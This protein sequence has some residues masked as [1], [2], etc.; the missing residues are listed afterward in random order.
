MANDKNNINEL[1][2]D[3][4]DSTAE[5]EVLDLPVLHAEVCLEAS[6]GTAGFVHNS[7]TAEQTELAISELTSELSSRSEMIDRL[8]FDMEILKTKSQGLATEVQA[9]EEQSRKLNSQLKR[10]KQIARERKKLVAERDDEVRLLRSEIE[11]REKANR[12]LP[13]ELAVLNKPLVD[14]DDENLENRDNILAVQAGQ[15]ASDG[16][17]I[18]EL[19]GRIAKIEE[20]ADHLRELLRD[21]DDKAKQ[22]D[23]S[24][25]SL[26]HHLQTSTKQLQGL[27]FELAE[28][29]EENTNLNSSISTLQETHAEEIRVIRFELGDAQET[30]SQQ[31]ST[32]Q[33]LTSDLAQTRGY[34][35]KLESLLVASEANSNSEIEKLERENQ[36]LLQDSERLREKLHSKSKAI[37]SLL[38]ELARESQQTEIDDD[39]GETVPEL[40]RRASG[41]VDDGNPENRDRVTRVLTGTI[42]GQE[43]RFPLF[44]DR[45]TIGRTRKND[46]Q[47]KS[48]HISR[49]HAVVVI[50]GDVTRVIDWGSKNG[51]FVNANRVKEHFLKNND[52]VG[53]GT[54]E[55]R[56]EERPKRDN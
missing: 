38:S 16:L 4:E 31:E 29:R 7:E 11:L 13:E 9:R 54:A 6:A 43:L 47:L 32:A 5:L 40:D 23:L 33:Q 52:I 37:G 28:A 35:K 1:V 24:S 14:G 39:T 42:D 45:L 48:E 36:Q 56:Y 22:L 19:K 21:R 30:L 46:I 10:A 26:Q 3:D 15:L 55:F 17:Q 27:Q 49:R 51:V 25:N 18:R 53:V 2:H 12:E 41:G 34:R 50:E 20:Y 44:K 8:Q